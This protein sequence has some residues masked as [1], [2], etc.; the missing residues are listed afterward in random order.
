M[1]KDFMIIKSWQKK[2]GILT[3]NENEE[4]W[5]NKVENLV[6]TFFGYPS[7]DQFS[8]SKL[9]NNTRIS[10]DLIDLFDQGKSAEEAAR[11]V[12][13]KHFGA[14]P[15][16]LEDMPQGEQ[17]FEADDAMDT[18]RDS[19]VDGE[20]DKIVSIINNMVKS[21]ELENKVHWATILDMIEK[22]LRSKDSQV[23]VRSLA[24]M[25]SWND[26][27][28]LSELTAEEK[29]QVKEYINAIKET[30]KAMMEILHKSKKMK[31]EDGRWGGPRKNMYLDPNK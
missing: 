7:G 24:D 16:E 23:T 10:V 19:Y 6:S 9:K 2:A 17:M 8:G 26:R 4:E 30:Q 18:G 22:E 20:I 25:P 11:I 15:E 14:S 29:E 3:E 5:N 21:P 12:L 31:N 28:K 1:D 13:Q 27:S